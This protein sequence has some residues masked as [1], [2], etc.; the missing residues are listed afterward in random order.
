MGGLDGALVGGE[1]AE[2][3]AAGG[4]VGVGGSEGG[5]V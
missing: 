3:G 5:E 1:G 2:E 4:F